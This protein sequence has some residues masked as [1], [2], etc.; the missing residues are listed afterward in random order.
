MDSDK[1]LIY[2]AGGRDF[3]EWEL[4]TAIVYDIEKEKWEYLPPMI[5]SGFRASWNSVFTDDKLY[6]VSKAT[7]YI[8]TYDP[9]TRQ[10][11]DIRMPPPFP[12]FMPTLVS[13]FRR[14]YKDFQEKIIEWDYLR[15]QCP[16]ELCR[17]KGAAMWN[18]Q[19]L[20]AGV[21][22]GDRM[23]FYLSEP[24]VLE[25]AGKEYKWSI[26]STLSK[27]DLPGMVSTIGALTL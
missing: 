13:A 23:V 3:Y 17:F 14:I 8:Q 10:W 11:S 4:R 9:K 21:G 6:L 20:M 7:G 15:E 5:W 19:I 16:P 2:I 26:L 18:Q 24:S 1:G 27:I 12:A 25:K 22:D